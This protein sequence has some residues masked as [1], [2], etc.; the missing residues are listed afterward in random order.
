MPKPYPR[1]FR[2]DVVRVARGRDPGVTASK[3]MP[4]SRTSNATNLEST[5]STSVPDSLVREKLVRLDP[6][7]TAQLN[8]LRMLV[9]G[10]ALRLPVFDLGLGHPAAQ[11]WLTDTKILRDLGLRLL[12]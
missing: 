6:V 11:P 7:L 8:Q 9:A 5:R 2:D 4:A 10:E 3:R 12:A 1:E